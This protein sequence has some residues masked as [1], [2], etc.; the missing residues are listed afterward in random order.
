MDTSLIPNPLF[1]YMMLFN[2]LLPVAALFVAAGLLMGF[3]RANSVA[4]QM[5]VIV[6]V[7]AVVALLAYFNPA[8][9]AGKSMVQELV[10][11]GLKAKPED[12]ALKFANGFL[13][14]DEKEQGEGTWSLVTKAG[15]AFFH[16]ILVAVITLIS[17]LALAVFYLAYLAQEFVL[18]IG[19]GWSPIFLGFLLLPST[20]STGLNFL[21]FMLALVLFPLGWGTASL[22]SDSLIKMATS[23]DQ[24]E[25]ATILSSLS[26][27]MRNFFGA[28]LLAVW[29]IVSTLVA[30]LAIFKALTTGAV[31]TSDA[32]RGLRVVTRS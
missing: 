23:W 12:V 16:G 32:F 19:I 28:L 14:H 4:E 27:G 10:H 11:D 15:K 18:E 26:F 6:Q 17:L 30:P 1:N 13:K 20:R 22:V 5:R 24:G 7:T 9:Q 21:L 25:N 3:E 8:V 29:I 31:I 2:L